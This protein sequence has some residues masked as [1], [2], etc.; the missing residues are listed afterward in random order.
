MANNENLIPFTS[1]QSREAAKKNGSK[2]GK[3]SAKARKKRKAMKEQMEMLL[4]L[5]LTDDKTRAFLEQMGIDTENMDNQMALVVATFQN[6]VRGDM[7]AVNI[8]REIIGERVQ[9]IA[10]TQVTDAKVKALEEYLNGKE[11]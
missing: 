4:K 7:K 11:E 8:V 9:E 10:I 1:E 6:A 3:A 5:P 2:G